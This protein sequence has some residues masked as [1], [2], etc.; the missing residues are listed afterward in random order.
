MKILIMISSLFVG[1]AENMVYELVKELDKS[2]NEVEVLC[3][4]SRYGNELE[5]KIENIVKVHYAQID[6]KFNLKNLSKILKKIKKIEPDIIHAHLG[7]VG[8][9]IFWSILHRTPLVVTIHTRPDKAFAKRI[10]SLL[11]TNLLRKKIKLVAVSKENEKLL[12]KYYSNREKYCCY[13]NN[14][15]SIDDF[16]KQKHDIYT[17]I[18]VARQDENKNQQAIIKCFCRLQKEVDCRLILVGEGPCTKLL[19]EMVKEKNLD[20]KVMFT[21]IVGNPSQYYA[22]ADCYVQASHREALPMSILE[23]IATGL[24][25][26][27]SNVGGIYEVVSD[28]NG[29]LY[30]DDDVEQLYQCMRKFF[31]KGQDW[32]ELCELKSKEL[33][34]KYSSVQMAKEYEAIYESMI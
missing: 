24:P 26:I 1:G 3:I 28:E 15:I 6:E 14:G 30:E 29:M 4:Q 27:S 21:G 11:K 7:G 31:F 25:I 18:N 32:I 23:A 19:K 13:V 22:K 16:G 10:D 34:K 12:K 20:D 33:A 9:G 8:Y 2:H 5:K 17:F